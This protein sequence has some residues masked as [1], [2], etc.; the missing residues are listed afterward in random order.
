MKIHKHIFG[1]VDNTEGHWHWNYNNHSA[2][3]FEYFWIDSCENLNVRKVEVSFK[4][5]DIDFCAFFTVTCHR[6]Y[7][8]DNWHCSFKRPSIT[9]Q[10]T[11]ASYLNFFDDCQF[12]RLDLA[13]E[14]ERTQLCSKSCEKRFF[15][16]PCLCENI[17]RFKAGSSSV[18]ILISTKVGNQ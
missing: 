13:E 1:K 5:Y 4:T 6:V 12:Y 2:N 17:F 8:A 11:R 15:K 9:S 18:T 16:D 14:D 3:I 7:F 10:S